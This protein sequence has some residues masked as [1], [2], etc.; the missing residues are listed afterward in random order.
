MGIALGSNSLIF[1]SLFRSLNVVIF[2]LDFNLPMH[3]DTEYL[4]NAT[5]PTRFASS[6]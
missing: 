1:L 2:W 4:V 6:S 3:I 5:P